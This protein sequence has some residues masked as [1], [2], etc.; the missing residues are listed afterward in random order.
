M[1]LSSIFRTMQSALRINNN[2]SKVIFKTQRL[3]ACGE[4]CR[5]ISSDANRSRE[6]PSLGIMEKVKE[7]PFF[8]RLAH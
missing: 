3:Q 8:R 4:F 1:Y 5:D 2:K 7:R 6:T